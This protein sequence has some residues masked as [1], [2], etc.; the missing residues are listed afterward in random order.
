MAEPCT[1]HAARK[2]IARTPPDSAPCQTTDGGNLPTGKSLFIL[3]NARSLEGNLG[4]RF[5]FLPLQQSQNGGH[6]AIFYLK[7]EMGFLSVANGGSD[8][9]DQFKYLAL[10]ITATS[11]RFKS[12]YVEFGLGKTELFLGDFSTKRKKIDAQLSFDLPDAKIK[13]FLQ[14]YVD[15]D[16]G[17]GSDSIQT[18]IGIDFD[19]PSLFESVLA[20]RGSSS[21]TK[22]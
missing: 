7:S 13:P 6:P 11:G 16:F 19:I 9:I 14:M 2:L 1:G 4:I 17:R 3:R 20:P 10:G 12:S 18:Y 15:S 22:D 21:K 8:I 5:E